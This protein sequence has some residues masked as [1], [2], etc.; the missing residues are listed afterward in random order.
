LV[1]NGKIAAIGKN[2]TDSAIIV[3]AKGK[4]LTA[5]LLMSIRIAIS[6]GVNEAVTTL[7][8]KLPFKT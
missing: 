5:E 7:A 6:N 3:D 8:P 2:I 1:K 4:H